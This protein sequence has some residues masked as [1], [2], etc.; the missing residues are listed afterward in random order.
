[1]SKKSDVNLGRIIGKAIQGILLI[2]TA[3]LVP[4]AKKKWNER[5]KS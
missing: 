1:M 5:K 3:I 2:G 4:K